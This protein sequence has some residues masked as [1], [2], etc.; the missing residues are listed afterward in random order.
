MVLKL[1]KG[2][3]ERPQVRIERPAAEK[4]ALKRL[5]EYAERNALAAGLD[6]TAHLIGVAALSISCVPTEDEITD[7]EPTPGR[8]VV[9]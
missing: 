9:D 4:Q 7:D 6:I 8:G 5:L 1:I 3:N 2:G